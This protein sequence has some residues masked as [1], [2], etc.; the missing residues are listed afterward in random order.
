MYLRMCM[1]LVA[2]CLASI[3]H[4]ATLEVPTPNTTVS[5]I[6]VISGWKCTAEGDITISLNGED[7]FPA[8]YGLPRSDTRSVCGD[9]G[10]NGFFSYWNWGNLGDGE[11]TVVAYDNGK[12][13]ARST[14]RVVTTGEEFLRGA[15]G[16]CE[17]PDFPAPGETAR[18]KWN[19]STQHLELDAVWGATRPA[20]G[21]LYWAV[22]TDTDWGGIQRANLDGS[23]VETLVRNPEELDDLV[24]DPTSGKLYWSAS[25]STGTGLGI[26]RANLDGSQVETLVRNPEELDDLVV[27]PTSGKLYWTVSTGTGTGLGIQCANLDGSQVE[28][29]VRNPEELDD[30]VV[31][32]TGGK[33]YW[34]A[35]PFWR[36]EADPD[37]EIRRANLDGSQVETLVRNPEELD[38]LVVDPTGGK[39][40]WVN[41]NNVGTSNNEIWHAEIRRANLDGS[42]VET[43][44]GPDRGLYNLVV[45]PT[46]GKLYWTVRIGNG[47]M[48]IQ[49]ANLDGSQVETLVWSS[50]GRLYNLVVDSVGGKLYW[51]ASTFTADVGIWRA[52][53][54]GSQVET[55][56]SLDGSIEEVK[57]F[58]L[59]RE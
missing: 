26:Q 5:G 11:H 10:N 21:K 7:P 34:T 33:L 49:R 50:D 44:V 16:T 22:R 58:F 41:W 9:D 53:L 24:V 3:S 51:T 8:T 1:A 32:P 40:Y 27:D 55:L 48:G 57:E 4:A 17:I 28:T 56:V 19:Q 2:V 39:L 15:S 35:S 52:N 18:F 29:L 6:G 38:D 59:V 54:D 30:L 46:G 14:F 31:D 45:D 13:F 42:Q 36:G 37:D 47:D 20:R 25:A 43:L 23:Q 12:E